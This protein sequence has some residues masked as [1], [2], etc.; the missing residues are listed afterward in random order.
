MSVQTLAERIQGLLNDPLNVELVNELVAQD[1]T[2]VSLNFENAEL[3][4]IMP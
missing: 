4:R 3:K 1:A 2:Y